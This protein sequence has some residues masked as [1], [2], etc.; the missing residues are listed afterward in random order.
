MVLA[1][2]IFADQFHVCHSQIF[3]FITKQQQQHRRSNTQTDN[4]VCMH[5]GELSG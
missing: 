1:K 4:F 3:S 5:T 2:F